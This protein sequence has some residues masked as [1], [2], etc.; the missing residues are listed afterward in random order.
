MKWRS[1]VH[2]SFFEW[3]HVHVAFCFRKRE[4]IHAEDKANAVETLWRATDDNPNGEIIKRQPEK[5]IITI[6]TSSYFLISNGSNSDRGRWF[7]SSYRNSIFRFV[8]HNYN[9]SAE[10]EVAGDRTGTHRTRQ[11]AQ[12][13]HKHE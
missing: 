9:G 11:E 5:P 2:S 4:K 7:D 8:T 1:I 10:T 3:F 6:P 12:T 13:S